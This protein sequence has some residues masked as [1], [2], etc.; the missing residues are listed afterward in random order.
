MVNI[1]LW[2]KKEI[3]TNSFITKRKVSNAI[4]KYIIKNWNE[5]VNIEKR[6]E[7]DGIWTTLFNIEL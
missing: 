1:S 4:K 7:K 6:L 2:S 5:C 3:D